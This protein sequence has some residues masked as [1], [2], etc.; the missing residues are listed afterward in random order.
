MAKKASR[1][2]QLT[3]PFETDNTLSWQEYP[4]PQ[5]KRDSYIS[6]CGIWQLAVKK[7]ETVTPVGNITVPY[8]PESRISGIDRPLGEDEKYIYTKN[9]DI[10]QN[11]INYRTLLHF[12]AV[13]TT[14]KVWINDAFVGEHTGG[15]LPFTLDIS[16][17][18]KTG[19][20]IITV[21]VEDA[22]DIDLAYGKQRKDRGGMWYTPVS[23]IWQPV[24]LESVPENHIE[25]IRLTPSL[26]DI[27]IEVTG[28]GAEKTLI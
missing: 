9:F 13:D 23:G 20:N 12:G 2:C 22:L 18:V 25:N 15:Y 21:E 19:E 14:A 5:L 17:V 27:T 7:E 8:P 1:T 24:W 26:T 6:L 16:S 11:F 4:R 28:G 10:P 3:T